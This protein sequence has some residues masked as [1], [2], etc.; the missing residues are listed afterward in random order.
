MLCLTH[1]IKYDQP[2]GKHT[3]Q[4]KHQNRGKQ[5]VFQLVVQDSLF[6]HLFTM[7]LK[8]GPKYMLKIQVHQMSSEPKKHKNIWAKETCEF[9]ELLL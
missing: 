2:I 4:V 3:G 5:K 1:N 8:I 7:L 6:L 9:K